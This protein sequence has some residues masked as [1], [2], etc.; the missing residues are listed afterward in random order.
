MDRSVRPRGKPSA[1]RAAVRRAP[2]VA[3]GV[4]AFLVAIC[5]VPSTAWA[6]VASL[7]ARGVSAPG[8]AV[9]I[10]R[11]LWISDDALGLCR[12][13]DPGGGAW[14]IA[15]GTCVTI[16]AAPGQPSFD[17]STHA[18]LPDASSHSSGVFRLTFDASTQ[19]LRD[20]VLLAP[21]AGLGPLR[22]TTTALGPDG[23][24]YIGTDRSSNVMRIT[25]PAGPVLA[26][27]VEVIGQTSDGAGVAAYGFVGQDLFVAEAGGV[28][29]FPRAASCLAGCVA[30]PTGM[31]APAATALASDGI[32]R[33][34]VSVPNGATECVLRYATDT[35]IQDVLATS[36]AVE[37]GAAPF[38]LLSALAV[39]PVGTVFAGDDPSGGVA[40]ATGRVWALDP[41]GVPEVAGEPGLPARCGGPPPRALTEGVLHGAGLTAP[42]GAVVIE[43]RLWIS[44]DVK[45]FCRLDGA[46]GSFAIVDS[47][48]DTTAKSPGQATYDPA[49][50]VVYVPDSSSSSLGV[51]RL[52]VDPSGATI[53]EATLLAPEAP[54]T[55]MRAAATGL[56]PD[57]KL[58][59]AGTKSASIVRITNP[60]GASQTVESVGR[61]SDLLGVRGLAFVGGDLYVAQS[62]VVTRI[63]FARECTGPPGCTASPAG[64]SLPVPT[65]IASGGRDAL[66][67]T[68]TPGE[69]ST[70][71]RIGIG[72]GIDEI[73]A[74]RGRMPD[75]ATS[76]L[77]FASALATDGPSR[78]FVADD[79]SDGAALGT[80]RVWR[81]DVPDTSPPDPPAFTGTTPVPPSTD[82][83]PR[84]RGSAEAGSTVSLYTDPACSS[85]AAAG[86]A[87][88]FT[89]PGLR[90]EVP[91][92]SSTTFYATATDLAGNVSVCSSATFEFIR[93]IEESVPPAPPSFDGIDPA[94]PANDN[95]PRVSGSAEAG[96][97]VSLYTDAD[98]TRFA[99]RGPAS[100]FAS[101][102]L[103]V[104]VPDD[105]RTTMF[106]IV[107]DA[108]GN[109]SPCARGVDYEEDST[110]PAPPSIPDLLPGS[111]S[112][113]ANDDDL[114]NDAT[115]T[116]VGSTDAASAV[117]VL[118]DGV[119]LPAD[120]RAD[121]SY[122]ATTDALSGGDHSLVAVATDAAGNTSGPSLPRVVTVDAVPPSAK[123][124]SMAINAARPLSR[125]AVPIRVTWSAV[126]S[127]GPVV[128]FNVE[129]S[130][131]AGAWS[132][133]LPLSPS[134]ATAKGRML[135]PG[136]RGYGYRV[137]AEDAAGNWGG[138]RASPTVR[139][140]AYQESSVS[141][142]YAG[143]WST[144]RAD[145]AFGGAVRSSS[146]AGA[147]ARLTFSG[148]SVGFVAPVG[149]SAGRA[150]LRLDG[151][152]LATI[153]LYAP[154]LGARE[155]PFVT[156]VGAGRHVLEV[157]VLARANPAS[158][159]T[160]VDLDA[161]VVL[162]D[163]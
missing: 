121:G 89:S 98:C 52:A 162:S 76:Q 91:D 157:R 57:G 139:V 15:A 160:R 163:G 86:S 64:L 155:I 63:A 45:G 72:R 10:D 97:T 1:P 159:G 71:H 132:D 58:Y 62:A 100:A 144:R 103:P 138:W 80:G 124:P 21:G 50:R 24:L 133:P 60:A 154:T 68:S 25:D 29:R 38:A 137:R 33:L 55:G 99:V 11:H 94:S 44:D 31:V 107:T 134:N 111:D 92:N 93:Y 77:E 149:P 66:Y 109:V 102:G 112:G 81:L 145:S 156:T 122:V 136:G 78:L 7:A 152:E 9:W 36:G 108:A 113:A 161:F 20:P 96:S 39:G 90:V 2:V 26:Q 104:A 110:P 87:A 30:E 84:I 70:V 6:A 67:V 128:A 125:T 75:G 18:Y 69:Q 129:E 43:G 101:P 148:S 141:I 74:T 118:V 3:A 41:A 151:T 126:D 123:A 17:G 48:C 59:V 4:A 22:L 27:R 105:S 40:L 79:P 53:G 28:T 115:P 51:W 140:E 127:P 47:T 23:K 35:E 147:T 116:V 32:G 158:A 85:A 37:A 46:P 83:T 14:T 95:A 73:V 146:S 88:D 8:G 82:N 56:G 143:G 34:Y 61:T 150:Q 114:T 119:A 130:R 16:A 120:V 12:L 131:E 54:L 13:D 65:A 49:E 5:V 106:G 135:V 153:D 117:S 19:T 42:A 142:A